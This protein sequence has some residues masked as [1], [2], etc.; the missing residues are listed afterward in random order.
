MSRLAKALRF[1]FDG[2]E[3]QIRVAQSVI[4]RES[5]DERCPDSLVRIIVCPDSDSSGHS[6]ETT[7]SE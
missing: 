3:E 5:E 4:L 1:T 6:I 7:F 2:T